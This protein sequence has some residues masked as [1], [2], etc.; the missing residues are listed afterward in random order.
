MS[1]AF[2]F[3]RLTE[4][5]EIHYHV[6]CINVWPEVSNYRQFFLIEEIQK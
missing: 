3:I 1:N 6:N 4:P 2:S 5:T